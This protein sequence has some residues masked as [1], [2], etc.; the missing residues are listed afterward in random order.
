MKPGCLNVGLDHLSWIETG[1]EPRSLEEGLL[2]A[3]LFAFRITDD[4]FP[5]II[6]FL[7]T[8]TT[9]EGYSTQQKEELVVQEVDFYVIAGYFYKMA[10]DE[11]LRRYVP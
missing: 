6:Q 2:D 1:D 11:I 8:G 7:S 4:H 3:Q 9:L 10:L 5:D